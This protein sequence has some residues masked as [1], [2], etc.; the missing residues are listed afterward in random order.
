[1]LLLIPAVLQIFNYGWVF[2]TGNAFN[3]L[4]AAELAGG[5]VS[6]SEA[7]QWRDMALQ[8]LH[9]ILGANPQVSSGVLRGS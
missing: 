4:V 1:M 9:Y 7:A 6:A 5:L 2:P 3:L 8:Q